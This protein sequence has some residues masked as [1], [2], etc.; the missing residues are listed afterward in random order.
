MHKQIMIVG[1]EGP[2]ARK[3]N[4]LESSGGHLVVKIRMLIDM[5][6]K[7][8]RIRLQNLLFAGGH[9]FSAIW[10]SGGLGGPNACKNI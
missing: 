7:T 8:M 4:D 6:L 9:M 5:L 2:N 3:N 1:P 10:P